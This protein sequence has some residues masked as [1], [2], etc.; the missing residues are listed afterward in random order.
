MTTDEDRMWQQLFRTLDR[1]ENG[2]KDKVDKEVFKE[3][4]EE[5]DGRLE[6]IE[7]E[8]H[9]LRNAAIT[10]DQVGT[11]IGSKLQESDARGITSRER[12]GRYIALAITIGTFLLLAV[13]K[14]YDIAIS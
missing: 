5:V 7:G 3:F 4:R 1:I 2:M 12:R 10:P 14:L 13:E 6:Q 9:A 11:M 8:V